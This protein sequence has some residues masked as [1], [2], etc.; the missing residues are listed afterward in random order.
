VTVTFTLIN[1]D[2][3]RMIASRRSFGC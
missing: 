2:P 3:R 1:P